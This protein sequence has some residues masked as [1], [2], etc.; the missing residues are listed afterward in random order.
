MSS[1]GMYVELRYCTLGAGRTAGACRTRAEPGRTRDRGRAGRRP[2]QAAGSARRGRP[3]RLGPS[4][5]SGA[6]VMLGRYEPTAGARVRGT[7]QLRLPVQV[8]QPRGELGARPDVE[9][10]VDPAEVALDRPD[11][12]EERGGDLAV[13]L[14]GGDQVSDPLLDRGE[15]ARSRAAGHRCWPA[16]A[17]AC[18]SWTGV[19]SRAKMPRAVS[20]V[21]A[22]VGAVT[23]ATQHLA[24]QQPGS[25][26]PRTASAPG[27]GRRSP[28]PS[29]RQR[30][31]R[32][33]PGWPRA[34][35]GSAGHRR[36][37]RLVGGLGARVQ[38]AR[39]AR[40]ASSSRP[41]ATSATTASGCRRRIAGS[42]M[43]TS[44]EE[45]A[46]ARSR[47][48]A[49]AG[50]SPAHSSAVPR[51][52]RSSAA[53]DV[54]PTDSSAARSAA[55]SARASVQVSLVGQREDV[56]GGR[57]RGADRPSARRAHVPPPRA[58]RRARTRRPSTPARPGGRG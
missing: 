38:L 42:R 46:S 49:A 9:L 45:T 52:R 2:T 30:R 58:R 23:G 10:A 11:A 39:S 40:A 29:S 47:C 37:P 50:T 57:H 12:G 43:P 56:H 13:G 54:K 27:A 55:P 24:E 7:T 15:L 25:A 1:V 14:A 20:S 31:P 44:S 16:R 21:A 32:G 18:R 5:S 8:G 53:A 6:A 48:S 22:G 26:P 19:P 4:R 35:R 33:R 28:A 34:A 17:R 3:S 41:S 36:R 51:L